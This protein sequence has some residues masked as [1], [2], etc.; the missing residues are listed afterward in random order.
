LGSNP[1][2]R[3]VD[4]FVAA[5]RTLLAALPKGSRVVWV[6]PP[7][8]PARL[9][10]LNQIYAAFPAAGIVPLDSRKW[11]SPSEA[12]DDHFNGA[13]GRAWAARVFAELAK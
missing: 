5:V 10:Y 6:G 1:D 13:P 12:V 7:P 11:L 4:D 9:A 2:G 3:T 8:M